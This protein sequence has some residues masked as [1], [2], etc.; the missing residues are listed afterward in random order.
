LWPTGILGSITHDHGQVVVAV[1]V[2][3][4]HRGFGIDLILNPTCV[5][6]SLQP[7]IAQ[8]AELERLAN[9]YHNLPALALAFSLKESVVKAVSPNIDRYLDLMD[10][11]LSVLNGVIVAYLAEFGLR[12]RC[13]FIVVE[14]ALL[15][16]AL[17]K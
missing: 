4:L 7:L 1:L 3:N 17:L 12:L 9:N 8:P 13:G 15:S 5:E 10:I 14:D 11:E 2:P 6:V 16:F